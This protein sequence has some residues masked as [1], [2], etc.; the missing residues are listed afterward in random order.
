[1]NE[2][3]N[4]KLQEKRKNSV[5]YLSSSLSD[6]KHS[7]SDLQNNEVKITTKITVQ[8]SCEEVLNWLNNNNFSSVVN[9]FQHYTGIDLLRLTMNDI[10]R[11]CNGDDSISIRLYNQLHEIVVAPLK[12]LYVKTSNTNIYSAIYLHT[13]TRHELEKKLFELIQQTQK[14]EYNLVFELDKIK[15]NID[16]D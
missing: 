16:N 10:R 1:E 14:D 11:I 3:C 6:I 2:N 9:R 15:I 7:Y 12:T 4:K 5:G 8:S 13:L